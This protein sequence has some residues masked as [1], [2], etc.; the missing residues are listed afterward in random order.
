MQGIAEKLF[1]SDKH[2]FSKFAEQQLTLIAGIGVDGDAHSGEFVR[3]RS[4]VL[5][6]P[7]QANLRQVHLMPMELLE[8]V[9]EKGFEVA[10]GALGENITTRGLDLISLPRNTILEIGAVMLRVEGLRNPCKQIEEFQAGLLPHMFGKNEAGKT[11]RKTGI[12]ATV[13]VGG[14]IMA[15]DAIKVHVP[16]REQYPL[17]VV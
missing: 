16:A 2:S 8:E 15:G 6:N 4:R 10:P 7:L 5:E 12:M 9:A 11:N 14:Q 13:M 17:E 3:H 1:R